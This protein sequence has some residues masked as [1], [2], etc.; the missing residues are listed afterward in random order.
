MTRRKNEA[1]LTTAEVAALRDA[2]D[3]IRRYVDEGSV[4]EERVGAYR[5]V[6]LAARAEREALMEVRFLGLARLADDPV[7]AL[8]NARRRMETLQSDRDALATENEVL[9]RRVVELRAAPAMAI[10]GGG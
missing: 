5:K 2:P 4:G 8:V 1:T 10:G 6:A 3:E 7:R 9:R